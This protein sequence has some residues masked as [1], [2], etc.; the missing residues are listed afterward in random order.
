MEPGYLPTRPTSHQNSGV[1][2]SLSVLSVLS[3]G[4]LRFQQH[5]KQTRQHLL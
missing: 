1:Y 5:L 4:G 2:F 3:K